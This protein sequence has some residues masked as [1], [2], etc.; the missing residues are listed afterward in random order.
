MDLL[1]QLE[2]K[3]ILTL[4]TIELLKMENEELRQEVE[5]LKKQSMGLHSKQSEW[6]AKVNSMLGQ[7]EADVAEELQQQAKEGDKL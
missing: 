1:E 6:E 7:F 5:S 4:D 3:I 2:E